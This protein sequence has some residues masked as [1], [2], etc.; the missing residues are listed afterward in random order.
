MAGSKKSKYYAYRL[1]NGKSGVLDTWAE[2]EKLVSGVNG[3]RYRSFEDPRDAEAWLSAGAQYESN[4]RVSVKLVA[5]I[6]FDAGTGRGAGVEASVTDEK[7]KDLLSLVLPKKDL[8]RFGKH[9]VKVPGATNN[10]GELLALRFA[11]EIAEQMRIKQI[12]GDSKLVVDFWSKWRIKRNDLPKKTVEL[13]SEV[14]AMRDAFEKNGGRIERIS[15]DH[16]P[17][18]LGFH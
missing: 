10:Y 1:P 12:F 9:P 4:E 17:A 16:N 6:Y 7:G 15:G 5:G 14:S 13:A 11:I 18:D 2:C 3:A 8:N